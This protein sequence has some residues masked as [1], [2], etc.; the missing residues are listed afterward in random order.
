MKSKLNDIFEKFYVINI[1]PDSE[2]MQRTKRELDGIRYERFP[3]VTSFDDE[4]ARKEKLY[5][6]NLQLC[7]TLSHLSIIKT[8]KEKNLKNVF[9]FEDDVFFDNDFAIYDLDLIGS[10]IEKN[11]WAMFYMG[12]IHVKAPTWVDVGITRISNTVAIHAYAVNG[13]YFDFM[14]DQIEENKFKMPI[15]IFY[16]YFVQNK[17]PCYCC[18]PRLWLQDSVKEYIPYLKDVINN[19]TVHLK[20]FPLTMENTECYQWLPR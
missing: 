12:G 16:A 11:D 10:F 18:C 7:I 5:V 6:K 4:I 8:A 19:N 3:A 9:I 15:D 13:K 2:R 17:F 1:D 20:L 14:I